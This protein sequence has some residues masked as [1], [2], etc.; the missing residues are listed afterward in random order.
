MNTAALEQ[1]P[2][3]NRNDSTYKY[4]KNDFDTVKAY[5]YLGNIDGFRH[6]SNKVGNL[7]MSKTRNILNF[8]DDLERSE[9][10]THLDFT[11]LEME[12]TEDAIPAPKLNLKPALITASVFIMPIILMLQSAGMKYL[13]VGVSSTLFIFFYILLLNVKKAS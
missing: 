12:Q 7:K 8:H 1:N 2:A 3:R 11:Y 13:F 9:S 6:S 4:R 10:F 5:R